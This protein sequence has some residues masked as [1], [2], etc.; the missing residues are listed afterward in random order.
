MTI[1]QYSFAKV[2]GVWAAAA[3][4][5]GLLGWVANPWLARSIDGASG[6]HGTARLLLL[7]VGLV[8]Q[9]VLTLILVRRESPALAWSVLR[10]R[11]WLGA[12]KNPRTGRPEA[13]L[14]LWLALLI[15]L[16]GLSVF[17]IAPALDGVWLTAFP[18]LAEP[19][20]YSVAS[21]LEGPGSRALEGAWWFFGLFLLLAVFNTVLGEELLFR[22]LLLPRMQGAFGRWDWLANGVLFGIYHVHQPW[23]LPSSVLD[24]VLLFALPT[25]LW[26]CAWV[27]IAVHSAQSAFFALV[28]LPAFVESA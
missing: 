12:P 26:R 7:T 28:L 18:S 4:P 9:F 15:P 5:M 6:I 13:R 14:W 11:L 22:G 2:V 17:V 23:G 27:G 24:G 16:F 19:A 20:E 25:K 10:E 3:L 21:L 1:P 8:W